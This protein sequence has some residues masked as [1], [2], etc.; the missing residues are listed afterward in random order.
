MEIK[1]LEIAGLG[2]ALT[3]LRLPFGRE[4]RSQLE[5]KYNI[6]QVLGTDGWIDSEEELP[7]YEIT[8]A[9]KDYA[10]MQ[11]L[12]KRGDEHAK[13]LRGIVVWAKIKAPIYAWC[14]LETYRAGHE[15]LCS[16]STMHIDCQGLSGDELV[17]AKREISMGKELTKIDLFSY[18]CLRNIY[19]Q[20]KDH[21]L[22]EWHEFCRWIKTLPFANELITIGL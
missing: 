7:S 11:T 18:Q 21:R 1:T 2:A 20:R 14:E 13:V 8:I 15:R 5:T 10:L 22:P 6:V 12:I 19:R 9:A 4:V 3:A 17:K 16:E